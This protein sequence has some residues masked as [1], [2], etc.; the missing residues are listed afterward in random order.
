MTFLFFLA[1][2]ALGTYIIRTLISYLS[3]DYKRP[4]T[5]QEQEM[6]LNK[7]RTSNIMFSNDGDG[8]LPG[9]DYRLWALD[10]KRTPFFFR[11]KFDRLGWVP[12]YSPVAKEVNKRFE[13]YKAQERMNTFKNYGLMDKGWDG[14]NLKNTEI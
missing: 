5:K 7:L 12:W 9:S 3:L 11:Y 4:L 14:S 6:L 13:E 1:F 10:F 2:I 8:R